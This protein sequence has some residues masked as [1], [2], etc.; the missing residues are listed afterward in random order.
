MK[1]KSEEN[2]YDVK[3]VISN[4]D[5]DLVCKYNWNLLRTNNEYVVFVDC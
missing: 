4:G 3:N 2:D 1:M 5:C